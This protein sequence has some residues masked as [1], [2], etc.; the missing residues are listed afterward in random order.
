MDIT[1]ELGFLIT[2]AL[3]RG[4]GA[5][6]ELLPRQAASHVEQGE[7]LW[8]SPFCGIGCS[9]LRLPK[10]PWSESRNFQGWTND[11]SPWHRSTPKRTSRN[12]GGVE[13]L[14][15][16]QCFNPEK[17]APVP[18]SW[19]T[20]FSGCDSAQPAPKAKWYLSPPT[21]HFAFLFFLFFLP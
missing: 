19:E 18:S 12:L 10:T 6:A 7:N 5:G 3:K 16:L 1:D 14:T 2:R 13:E 15:T 11:D 21:L 9:K 20:A 4:V 17:Q 8:L